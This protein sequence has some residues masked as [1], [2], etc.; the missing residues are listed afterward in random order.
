MDAQLAAWRMLGVL[1]GVLELY[2]KWRAVHGSTAYVK[3][4]V[5][6]TCPEVLFGCRLDAV[7][8]RRGVVLL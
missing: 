5:R 8:L 2:C 7:V 3:H 6:A 1:A 4:L